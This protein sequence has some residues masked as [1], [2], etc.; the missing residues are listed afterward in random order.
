MSSEIKK[1]EEK[2]GCFFCGGAQRPENVIF[3]NGFFY[4]QFDKFPVTPGHL[5]IIPKKHIDSLLDLSSE[6]WIS[7]KEAITETV[8]LIEALDL[9]EVYT[10]F[11][12]KP[13]NEKSEWFCRQMLSYSWIDKKPDGYNFGNNDGEAAGRTIHHL[14]VHVIPRYKGDIPDPRGGIRHI[15]PGMGNYK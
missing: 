8:H 5:E 12:E 3:E 14:H 6:E 2:S 9:K 15:I 1:A 10:K 4:A 7:L 11:L 13:V